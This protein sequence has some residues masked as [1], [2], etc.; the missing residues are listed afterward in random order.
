MDDWD[1]EP[2]VEI[3]R[4]LYRLAVARSDLAA[5]L[6]G[7]NH[8]LTE[9]ID[10]GSL[11]YWTMHN[12]IV[13]S[14]GRPFTRNKPFGPISGDWEPLVRF[15]DLHR[16]LLDL[17]HNCVA[18]SDHEMRK[19]FIVPAGARL[20]QTGDETTIGL[21]LAVQNWALPR[22]KWEDVRRLCLEL[23]GSIDAHRQVTRGR[24]R[25]LRSWP[26]VCTDTA[27]WLVR[28]RTGR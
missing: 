17:R 2:K 18:H 8:L 3:K 28:G 6:E 27:F 23:G 26:G 25:L 4:T 13:V 14:Y 15:A 5:A 16:E 19:V 11:L 7:C 21:G 1:D 9:R 24:G 20:F 12:G 22:A 10:V